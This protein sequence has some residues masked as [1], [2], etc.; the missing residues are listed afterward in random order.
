[1]FKRIMLAVAAA[2]MIGG[3]VNVPGVETTNEAQ[4]SH[5]SRYNRGWNRGYYRP[6]Y[7]SY[8]RSYYRPY[9]GYGYGGYGYS[10]GPW[11][12]HYV[13]TPGFYFSW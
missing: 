1:M 6:Y 7:G 4:A 2:A 8:H 9:Y 13:N 5:W 11:G 3:A 10:R 12:R